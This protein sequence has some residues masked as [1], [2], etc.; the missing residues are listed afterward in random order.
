MF[1]SAWVAEVRAQ[2]IPEHVAMAVFANIP[3]LAQWPPASTLKAVC[4]KD[5]SSVGDSVSDGVGGDGVA[6][7]PHLRRDAGLTNS[8]SATRKRNPRNLPKNNFCPA[9]AGA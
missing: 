4:I 3:A 6:V 9:A 1:L 8:T 7:G 5:G 2:A